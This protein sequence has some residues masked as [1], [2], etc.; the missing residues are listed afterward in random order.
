MQIEIFLGA[1]QILHLQVLRPG[2]NKIWCMMVGERA[3]PIIVLDGGE[4]GSKIGLK[5]ELLP[6]KDEKFCQKSF[7]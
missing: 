6:K 5:V 1:I 2:S 7:A 4:R 3:W